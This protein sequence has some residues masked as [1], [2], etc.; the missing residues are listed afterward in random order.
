MAGFLWTSGGTALQW[1]VWGIDPCP[2]VGGIVS[3]VLE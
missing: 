1:E 3:S 2:V